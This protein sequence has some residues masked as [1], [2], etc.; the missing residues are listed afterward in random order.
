MRYKRKRR[1]IVKIQSWFRGVKCRI[2]VQKIRVSKRVT[3]L[4][5]LFRSKQAKVEKE[6]L[7][8]MNVMRQALLSK[9]QRLILR[10]MKRFMKSR[11]KT[12]HMAAVKIQRN[13][14][15][16]IARINLE[17]EIRKRKF[18]AK[19][20]RLFFLK[21]KK[22]SQACVIRAKERR[23]AEEENMKMMREEIATRVYLQLYKIKL[24]KESAEARARVEFK[25]KQMEIKQQALL[26]RKQ[27]AACLIQ[28]VVRGHLVWKRYQW[29]IRMLV[30]VQSGFRRRRVMRRVR[31]RFSGNVPYTSR[32]IASLLGRQFFSLFTQPMVP[33][34]GR[35]SVVYNVHP[36]VWKNCYKIEADEYRTTDKLISL[37]LFTNE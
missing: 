15:K 25:I 30:L 37:R 19:Y 35:K 6:R 31:F 12:R 9:S 22:I 1:C 16:I 21:I 5:S 3:A 13:M 8:K 23:S 24:S 4:Q 7:K 28:K 29:I 10:C 18:Y 34:L 33:V 17:R 11:S 26:L 2:L 20:G 27:W 36:D 32:H 14:L